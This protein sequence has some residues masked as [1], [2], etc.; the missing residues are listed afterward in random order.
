ASE[1]QELLDWAWSHAE[2]RPVPSI[3]EVKQEPDTGTVMHSKNNALPTMHPYQGEDHDT[4]GLDCDTHGLP[5]EENHVYQK[6]QP[7]VSGGDSAQPCVSDSGPQ[8]CVSTLPLDVQE[9]AFKHA[10][11]GDVSRWWS[12]L[13]KLRRQLDPFARNGA[14]TLETWKAVAAY[15]I[16]LCRANGLDVPGFDSVWAQLKKKLKTTIRE[17]HGEA[18]ARVRSRIPNV[19]VA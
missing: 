11:F 15:W 2:S 16:K 4:H 6:P 10:S 9:I 18:L 3:H 8:P 7:C 13:F 17:P 19:I 14:W 5:K 1:I 12:T